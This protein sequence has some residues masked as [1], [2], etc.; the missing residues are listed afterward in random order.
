M[1][2]KTLYDLERHEQVVLITAVRNFLEGLCTTDLEQAR[3]G[4]T[5]IQEQLMAELRRTP[6]RPTDEESL[7]GADY[8]SV[9]IVLDH[10]PALAHALAP[11]FSE[12]RTLRLHNRRA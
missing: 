11:L 7:T 10:H 2:R 12:S 4:L 5:L 8:T 3:K 9:Q 1:R 6:T